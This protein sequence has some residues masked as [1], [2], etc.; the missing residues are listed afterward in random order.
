MAE[1]LRVLILAENR[2][3]PAPTQPLS[4]SLYP[5][6][7]GLVPSSGPCRHCMHVHGAETYKCRQIVH[8][9]KTKYKFK[10]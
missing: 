7:E 2:D 1:R 8:T 9:H 10:L 5:D 4:I 6:P 3:F